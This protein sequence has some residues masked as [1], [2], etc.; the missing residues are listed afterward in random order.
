MQNYNYRTATVADIEQLKSV[1]LNSFGQFQSQ[2]TAD[3]WQKLEAILTSENTYIGLLNISTC[4]VCEDNDKI[5]G[6][7]FFLSN[8]NPTDV[9]QADWAYLRMVGVN[10]AYAGKGIGRRLMEICIDHARK[11][12]ETKLALHTSEFMDAARHIYEN[13]GFVRL[14]EIDSRLG[15]RYWLYL[16]DL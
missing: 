12:N 5:I 15:K 2:L 10:S 6:M 14:K 7:A 4:F 16:L 9:F 1:G 11:T 13:M 8:G 3:N